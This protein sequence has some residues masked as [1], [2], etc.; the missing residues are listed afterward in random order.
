MR[1]RALPH[2]LSFTS[3]IA[4]RGSL[5]SRWMMEER[6][7]REWGQGPGLYGLRQVIEPLSFRIL[8]YKMGT[9][10]RHGDKD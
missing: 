10:I 3:R 7:W 9:E 2:I 4:C 8:V 6:R 5:L 1:R